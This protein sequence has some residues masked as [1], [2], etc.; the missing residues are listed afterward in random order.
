[1]LEMICMIPEHIGWMIVGA[2]GMACAVMGWKVGTLIYLAIKER[3]ED[4]EDED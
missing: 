4:D 2:L 3:L 1:M